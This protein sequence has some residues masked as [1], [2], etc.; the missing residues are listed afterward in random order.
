MEST[1]S[2]AG[3]P[4]FPGG[5]RPP[6]EPAF[7]RVG[8]RVFALTTLVG[9]FA[10]LA[11]R[12]GYTIDPAAWFVA[13]PLLVA[14]IHNAAGL[15]LYTAQLWD[16]D[17][18]PPPRVP[19]PI[20]RLRVAVLLPT[21]N[22]PEAILLPVIA[23]AVALEPAHETW[24][25]DDGHRPEVRELA[26]TLGAR[27]LSRAGTEHAKAGNLNYALDR[28]ESDVVAVLDA[29]HVAAPGFLTKTLPYF[30][31][32]TVAIVQ[33]PQDFY[34]RDSFEHEG[35][36]RGPG[37]NEEAVF[38]RVIAPG[39]NKWGA[40][41]WCGTGALVRVEALRSVGGVATDSVT[42]DI[43]TTIRMNRRGWQAVYHNEVLA[44]GLAPS[45]Y[46]QYA[47]QRNRWATGAMQ[48][49]RMENPL[50]S[51]GLTF[52]QRL[53]FMTT[54]A[55]WFDSWRAFLYMTIPIAVVLTGASPIAAPGNI[56]VPL[57][58]G[59][60]I[61]QFVALRLLARGYYPPVLSLVFEVLRM[62]AVLPATLAVFNPHRPRR[63]RVTPKGASTARAQMPVPRL[64]SGLAA[65]SVLALG[66]FA[67]TMAGLTP[68]H[69]H[70]P[71]ASIGAALF[72][73]GNLALLVIAIR[74][75]RDE[76]FSPDRRGSHRFDVQVLAR[77]NGRPCQVTDLS[78]T[79]CQAIVTTPAPLPGARAR[80]EFS[81]PD[82][83]LSFD[84]AVRRVVGEH[85][86]TMTIGLEFATGQ[87]PALGH[88]AVQ[89]FNSGATTRDRLD[90]APETPATVRRAA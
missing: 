88:L 58:L 65:A 21:Y 74:R 78:M 46:A 82:G 41:F 2:R 39:K 5:A 26:D 54:L 37:F 89:L 66:F 6:R 44:R 56:F 12:I 23:A 1:H 80:L 75:I 38:Y 8:T 7:R 55:G 9:T 48:V 4:V 70:T 60:F 57:F 10:Y 83:P 42:E 22:E 43:H 81:L 31:D 25:L 35:A 32:A 20:N 19:L 47:L 87:R 15:V 17:V 16:V 36:Q 67:A 14:E 68:F 3:L 52:G 73:M 27:Y 69:Y 64:L 40:A 45:D 72:M 30:H 28:I 18:A 11:W 59:T 85:G 61:A 76:R 34:N 51:R 29:D 77:M 13:I 84:C 62:P 33:T 90:P 49:L 71:A 63:F 50:F 53:G 24:V 79:G 86:N